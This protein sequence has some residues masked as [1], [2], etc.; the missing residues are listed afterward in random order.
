MSLEHFTWE[1][2]VPT[3]GSG[4]DRRHTSEAFAED[5]SLYVGYSP[6]GGSLTVYSTK[7]AS[8]APRATSLCQ[9]AAHAV[10][11][12]AHRFVKY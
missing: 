10:I 11:F 12:A 8:G 1:K 6:N 5:G 9:G 4:V 3:D 7:I 2:L